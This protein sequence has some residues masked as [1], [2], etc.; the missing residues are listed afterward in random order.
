MRPVEPVG[1][2]RQHFVIEY[3]PVSFTAHKVTLWLPESVDVY[4]QYQSHY[5]H[6]QHRFSNFK[7]FW[8]GTS[9]KIE[10]PKQPAT[11]KQ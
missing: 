10:P 1:L 5:L 9:Q 3:A 6:H 8:V 11:V 4:I 7:L 2:K